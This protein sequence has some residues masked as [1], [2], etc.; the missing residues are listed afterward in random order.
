MHLRNRQSDTVCKQPVFLSPTNDN[1]FSLLSEE[2]IGEI[3][4]KLPVKYIC[5]LKCVCKSWKTLISDPQFTK[6][7]L[8]IKPTLTDQRLVFSVK[9]NHYRIASYP[10]NPLSNKPST[11]VQPD[12]FSATEKNTFCIIG[13]CNGLL[14]LFDISQG[15]ARLCNPSIKWKS[16]ISPK[17]VSRNLKVVCYGFGYDQVNDKYKVLIVLQ[18]KRENLTKVYTF[19][20]DSWKTIQNFP[21]SPTRQLG[22]F[23][24]GTLNWVVD[25]RSASSSSNQMMILSFNLEKETYAE[26]LLPQNDVPY[27]SKTTLYVI[28]YC[29]CVCYD[30]IARKKNNW[31]VWMMKEYGVAESWTKVKIIPRNLPTIVDPMFVSDRGTFLLGTTNSFRLIPY[32]YNLYDCG[33]DCPFIS[34]EGIALDLHIYRESMISL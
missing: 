9:T 8:Q 31:S 12:L 28:S 10:L 21:Y 29:L 34:L 33:L 11:P 24:S 22:K 16:K 18:N 19:G 2:L 30:A 4:L 17:A 6:T 1:L 20:E 5:Q 3:F 25:K 15:V 26:L 23:V 13:S 7:H 27:G 32:V 14:C